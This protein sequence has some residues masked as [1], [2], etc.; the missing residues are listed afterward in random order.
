MRS[1]E[2]LLF[3]K[4][5]AIDDPALMPAAHAWSGGKLTITVPKLELFEA[6]KIEP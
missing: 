6:F 1:V 3:E 2:L 4:A 5:P